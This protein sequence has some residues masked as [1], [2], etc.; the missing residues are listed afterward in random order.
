MIF[1][2]P[3]LWLP[4]KLAHDISPF[5]LPL[6]S[7]NFSVDIEDTGW[8]PVA[9][10]DLSFSNP[11]GIAGGVDKN[12]QSLYDWQSLGAG[13]LE[14]GTVTPQPQEANPGPIV[15]RSYAQRALWNKMGFPNKGVGIVRENLQTFAEKK[16]VPLFVNIGKNRTTSNLK[17]HEDYIYCMQKL[18][19]YADAFV[20]NVSSPNT[21]DLRDLQKGDEFL[22]FLLKISEA[23]K[24]YCAGTPILLKLSPDLSSRELEFILETSYEDVDGWILANT[25]KKRYPNSNFPGEGGISGRPLKA[26]SKDFLSRAMQI[27]GKEKKGKLVVS[28]G[29]IDDASEIKERLRIGADLVQVYS[30]LIF[31]GPLFFKKALKKLRSEPSS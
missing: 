23:K 26:S 3:W 28:V 14:L 12:G 21:R 31:E 10:K 8:K 17:A 22:Q 4:P 6:F 30:A 29:G 24:Q 25:T 2:K 15:A 20:I 1:T 5:F 9:W 19:M 16:K 11:M 27:L 18:Y 13:F 7:K